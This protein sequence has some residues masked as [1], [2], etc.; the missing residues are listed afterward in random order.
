VN[1]QSYFEQASKILDK[2]SIV[3]QYNS[4]WLGKMH[5]EDVI[6]L[7]SAFTVARM[8][9][10]DE[11]E[12][13]FKNQEPIS[14]H[15]FLY[16]LAQAMDSVAIRSDIELGGTDQ[17]FNLLV[18]REIQREYGQEPQVILTMP[19]LEGTD[20]VEKMSKSLDNYI[21][22]TDAPEDMYGKVLSIPDKMILPW[23]RLATDTADARV[24]EIDAAMN[25]EGRNPRDFKRELARTIVAGYHSADAATAAEDHFDRVFRDK[26][27]P[28]DMEEYILG[29]ESQELVL[30]II[31]QAGLVASRGDGR[32]MIQQ[33]A[34]S[35]NNEKIT[36]VNAPIP[37]GEEF[38]IKVGKRRFLRVIRK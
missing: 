36:D 18:G 17:K 9:E 14:I 32:R 25:K 4:E 29:P 20:G 24:A 11:F 6:K 3:I 13:R 27:A 1:G 21:A 33:M 10:R 19:L 30:D 34:V 37:A 8:L 15:E 23:F 5:F 7:A 22:F 38:V 12:K 31:V 2:D 28:E 35:M 26:L 16:P